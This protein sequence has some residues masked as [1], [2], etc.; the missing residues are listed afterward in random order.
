MK[1]DFNKLKVAAYCRVST[2]KSDQAN[3]LKSQR[4]FFYKYISDNPRLTLYG[5]YSDEGVS[6]TSTKKRTAFNKMLQDAKDK[7]F[8]LIITKEIS[9]F[10]RNTVDSIT[11]T[12]ELKKIGV[13]VIFLNDGINTLENDAELRLAIM[14]TIAQEESRRTSE[15]VKWGQKRQM[16]NG[17]VFG[18]DLFGYQV[19]NG[20]ITINESEAETVR[21]IFHKFLNEG[22]GSHTIAAELKS[23]GAETSARMNEWTYSAVLRILK[24]E[25]Y[26]GDLIQQKTYT[27]DYLTH[28]KKR[29]CGEVEKIVI[30]NHHEAIVSRE[31]FCAAQKELK[32]RRAYQKNEDS[33]RNRYSLS[34][35]IFCENCE[36]AFLRRQKTLKSGKKSVKWIC[37]EKI[38]Q[39]EKT[40]PCRS[41]CRAGSISDSDLKEA[42]MKAQKR[43][44]NAQEN[45]AEKLF[46]AISK[47]VE[48]NGSSLNDEKLAKLEKECDKTQQKMSRLLDIYLDGQI[49]YDEFYIKKTELLSKKREILKKIDKKTKFFSNYRNHIGFIYD[50]YNRGGKIIKGEEWNEIYYKKMVKKIIVDGNDLKIYLGAGLY[51]TA[52]K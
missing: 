6:G 28:A 34:G 32:K 27:P 45:A 26:C 3:S 49:D 52:F 41:L 23:E 50:L 9:R 5:I 8:D 36:K 17:V 46:E 43:F 10:A 2:D 11:Y 13:G 14:A 29:N 51:E 47:A 42:V 38:G 1:N 31:T 48:K 35:K 22:K 7:K 21:L 44:L 15:R 39:A 20:K 30:R 40:C 25:K 37:P 16:E 24:N 33:V 18:R 4:E 12:R 19:Q